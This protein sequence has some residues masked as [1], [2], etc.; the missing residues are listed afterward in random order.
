MLVTGLHREHAKA[1]SGTANRTCLF[2]DG[3]LIYRIPVAS[4]GGAFTAQ[5]NRAEIRRMTPGISIA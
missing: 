4:T 5:S 2:F 3:V 1:K